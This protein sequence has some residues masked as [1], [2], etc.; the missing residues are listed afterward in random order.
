ML[1]SALCIATPSIGSRLQAAQPGRGR[2][3]GSPQATADSLQAF[4]IAPNISQSLRTVG[5]YAS[6]VNAHPHNMPYDRC[7][8]IAAVEEVFIIHKLESDVIGMLRYA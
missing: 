2:L 3:V 8:A 1:L 4:Q 7:C 6:I 5:P